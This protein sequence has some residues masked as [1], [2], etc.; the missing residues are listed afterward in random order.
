L[1]DF[2]GIPG[3]FAG[4][5]GRSGESI[6]VVDRIV[7]DARL[8]V[9]QTFVSYKRFKEKFETAPPPIGPAGTLRRLD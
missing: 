1:P 7:F 5:S 8:T 9:N 3:P 4:R 6:I 2:L